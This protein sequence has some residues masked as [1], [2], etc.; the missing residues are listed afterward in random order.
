MDEFAEDLIELQHRLRRAVGVEDVKYIRNAEIAGRLCT[1]AGFATAWL[2]FNPVSIVFIAIG[3]VARWALAHHILHRAFDGI[4]GVP[5]RFK[6]SHFGRGWRRMIDWNEWM[7]PAGFQHEHNVHHVYTGRGEDPD[8]VEA[9]VEYIRKSTQPRWVKYL[10]A[11]AVALTW[12]L[13][14]YAPGTFVQLRRKQTGLRPTRYEF[15]CMFMF[16]EVFNP[17]SREGVRFWG[18]CI[19][20]TLITRFV[21]LPAL[22]LPLGIYAAVN[23][24]LSVIAAELLTNFYTFILIASSHTGDDIY[25]FD[26]G[27]RGRPDF[28][29]HQ[30]LGTVNY[31]HGPAIR[32][33]LQMWIN[34]QIEHHIFP[35]LPPSQYARCAA[36]VRA[37]C[38][39]HGVP[40]RSEPLRRRVWRMLDIVVGKT[41]MRRVLAHEVV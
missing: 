13:S 33:F 8:V 10:M 23:V 21:I 35:N 14:Y 32:D 19:L 37:I 27:T 31:Q 25:R 12:R 1:V 26:V 40:Y 24:L 34:Y 9:N 3:Q 20:P 7:L 16:A 39:K 38:Q 4:E 5:N 15:N 17:F 2:L 30:L 29:R 41:T 36:E 11:L 18:L 22:F 28:Y 6:G